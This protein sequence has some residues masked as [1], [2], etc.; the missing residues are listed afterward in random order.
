[1]DK[2]IGVVLVN[3]VLR[4]W[5]GEWNRGHPSEWLMGIRLVCVWQSVC[6]CVCV[7]ICLCLC[8]HVFVFDL[9]YVT[10]LLRRMKQMSSCCVAYEN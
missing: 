5:C 8:S 10:S 7:A 3:L 1:M 4:A 2:F 6:V 9:G